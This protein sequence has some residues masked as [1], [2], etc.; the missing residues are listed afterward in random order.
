M[1]LTCFY[2]FLTVVNL[3]LLPLSFALCCAF[4]THTV[5]PFQIFPVE[6]Q[7]TQSTL[8]RSS[9]QSWVWTN[10]YPCAPVTLKQECRTFSLP[11][12]VPRVSF[13]S[14][15]YPTRTRRQRRLS[16]LLPQVQF[17]VLELMNGS[18]AFYHLASPPLWSVYGI[19][20]GNTIAVPLYC[21]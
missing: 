2:H 19:H 12:K 11:Q 6:I 3:T 4:C 7:S 10:V 8:Q 20:L 18:F 15:S 14:P 16:F 17:S 21:W 13:H 1:L 9:V 5:V